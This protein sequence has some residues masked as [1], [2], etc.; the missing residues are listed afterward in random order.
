MFF[1]L[2]FVF[3]VLAELNHTGVHIAAH[4]GSVRQLAASGA[5]MT[6]EE[7]AAVRHK[8]LAA[9]G[10]TRTKS[11]AHAI[12][13]MERAEGGEEEQTAILGSWQG[14]LR[15]KGQFGA[16]QKHRTC[17][18]RLQQGELV[19]EAKNRFH[20]AKAATHHPLHAEFVVCI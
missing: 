14:V 1:V 20:K 15:R 11:E 3:A 7:E 5:S 4:R 17:N 9:F 10:S 12:N 13:T 6:E 2:Y 19:V 16:G 8:V 18:V